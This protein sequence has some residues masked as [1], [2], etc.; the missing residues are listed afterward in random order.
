MP[1][2]LGLDAISVRN[3]TGLTMI[4]GFFA[5][6]SAMFLYKKH[7]LVNTSM[8]FTLGLFSSTAGLI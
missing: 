2:L 1:P 5:S 4:H 6:L 8:V 7:N 3:I